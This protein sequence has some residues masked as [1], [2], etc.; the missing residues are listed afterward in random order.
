MNMI[1]TYVRHSIYRRYGVVV[2]EHPK[3]S[4]FWEIKSIATYGV[5]V[6]QCWLKGRTVLIG[7]LIKPKR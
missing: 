4:R 3:G 5:P 2:G 7:K 1:G 6:T